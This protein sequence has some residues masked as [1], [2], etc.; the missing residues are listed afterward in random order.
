MAFSGIVLS[1]AQTTLTWP[2]SV[3]L[4][5]W[6]S[7]LDATAMKY[8]LVRFLQVAVGGTVVHSSIYLYG[9]AAAFFCDKL[10]EAST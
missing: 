9:V 6:V 5:S 2:R 8:F 10:A 1:G 4:L 7:E 3:K